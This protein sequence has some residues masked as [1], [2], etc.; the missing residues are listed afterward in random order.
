MYLTT[1]PHN[2]LRSYLSTTCRRVFC[3]PSL[4]AIS[5]CLLLVLNANVLKIK[6]SQN[7]S[8]AILCVLCAYILCMFLK[9]LQ[10]KNLEQFQYQYVEFAICKSKIITT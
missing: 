4:F 9:P 3:G 2:G 10:H 7:L 8:V 1:L 5:I 6:I